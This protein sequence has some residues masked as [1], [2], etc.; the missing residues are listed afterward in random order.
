[1]RGGELRGD[2]AELGG[3]GAL[4]RRDCIAERLPPQ[5]GELGPAGGQGG[6]CRIMAAN[7]GDAIPAVLSRRASSAR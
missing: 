3:V 4:R 1:M 7:P 6:L 2:Q 5:V